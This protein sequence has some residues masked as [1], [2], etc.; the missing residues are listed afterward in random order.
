ME[1]TKRSLKRE[2]YSNITLPFK[3]R[4][5]SNR[6]SNLTCKATRKRIPKKP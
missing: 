1:Y 4:K 2:V 6:P 3:T 5:T